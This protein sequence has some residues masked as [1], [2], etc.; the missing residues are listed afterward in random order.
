MA[1][2][3]RCGDVIPECRAVV[4]GKDVAEVMKK[5]TKHTRDKHGM[6]AIS[7]GVAARLEAAIK[8]N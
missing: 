6:D 7:P 1:K 2:I 4:E 3:F 5:V 8:E